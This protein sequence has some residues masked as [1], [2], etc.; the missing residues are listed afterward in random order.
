MADLPYARG[1]VL[2]ETVAAFTLAA[3]AEGV[4]TIPQAAVAAFS[5][6]LHDW[7][8]IGEDRMILCAISFGYSDADH[9]ANGFRTERAPLDEFVDWR[10]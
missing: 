2:P 8:D 5:T 6:F 3:R 7:F 10:D 4:A 9:P 1:S